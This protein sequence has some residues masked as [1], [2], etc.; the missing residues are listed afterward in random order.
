MVM[1]FDTSILR[2]WAYEKQYITPEKLLEAGDQLT[3]NIISITVLL[4]KL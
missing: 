1:N 4:A 3:C 2:Y